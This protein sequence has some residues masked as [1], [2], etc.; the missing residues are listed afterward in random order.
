MT[1]S[2]RVWA[3]SRLVIDAPAACRRD[4]EEPGN[5]WPQ[6]VLN[7]PVNGQPATAA[8]GS[9]VSFLC[10]SRVMVDRAWIAALAAGATDEGKPGIRYVYAPDF[11]A[12][13]CL[14]LK[15]TSSASFIR[16]V[17]PPITQLQVGADRTSGQLLKLPGGQRSINARTWKTSARQARPFA[18]P[19]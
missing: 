12:A 10:M 7:K 8:Y 1:W 3:G 9:Q 17:D 4:L 15:V 5:R 16:M 6:F 19:P 11:S 2:C 18:E 13:Y 14:V